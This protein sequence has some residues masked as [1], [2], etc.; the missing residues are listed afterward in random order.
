[1]IGELAFAFAA[2]AVATPNPCGFALLPAYLA[3][4]LS[5]DSGA[6]D[7]AGTALRA[8]TLGAAATGGFLLVFAGVG[9]AVA[10]GLRGLTAALPGL[11]FAVGLALFVAGLLVLAGRRVALPM[12]A[13]PP[14]TAVTGLAGDFV[15]G[16]GYGA[17][18]LSCTLPIFL[19]VLGS[20][21][22]GGPL[23]GIA[24][25]AAYALGMGTILMALAVAAALAR[26]GL[27]L[28]I[29]RA[30][31]SVH[32]ASGALLALAGAYVAYYWAMAVWAPAAA[33]RDPVIARGELLSAQLRS[34]L[35]TPDGRAVVYGLLLALAVVLLWGLWR[36][37]V[38]R[39]ETRRG[40]SPES[41]AG[42][43][44]A[45]ER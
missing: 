43:R 17:A 9:G 3:R 6:G 7:G 38:A 22:T 37:G 23:G 2:G 40:T 16:L 18:S 24:G 13:L 34:W 29:R 35:S 42:P 41:P 21:T 44:R 33:P 5:D 10:A 14:S 36:R 25:L 1:M 8:I 30:L 45:R 28:T 26:H 20:A 15:F 39:L 27:V 12:P 11:G 32:R 4:R 31:L 19:A